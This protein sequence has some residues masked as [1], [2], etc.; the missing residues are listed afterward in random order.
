MDPHAENFFKHDDYFI[1]E[2][3]QFLK[4]TNT[5]K[6]YD[7]SGSQ[8]GVIQESMSTALK[9]LSLILG[10][11]SM[12]FTLTIVDTEDH[13]LATIKRGWTLFMSRISI[14][15]G[16]GGEI[17]RIKQKFKMFKPTFHILDLNDAALATISGDWKAWNFTITG[18]GDAQIGTITKKWSGL[19]KE[20]FTTA[21]KYIVSIN[22][23]V[24]GAARIATVAAA[25]TI[26]MV[27]KESKS[28]RL[29]KPRLGSGA[30]GLWPPAKAAGKNR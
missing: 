12:P 17:A 22:A 24:T 11:A 2:K 9:F 3:V 1:D 28:G 13:V 18:E 21:D 8:I 27:L 26:D 14:Y 15:D 19:L 30:F 10:K 29:W 6:V 20:A 25:I 4:F 16:E 7:S 23:G 5:Y